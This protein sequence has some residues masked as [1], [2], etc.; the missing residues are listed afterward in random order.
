MT[1]CTNFQVV[2]HFASQSAPMK[3]LLIFV[4]RAFSWNHEY[5]YFVCSSLSSLEIFRSICGTL[6]CEGVLLDIGRN[7]WQC[8]VLQSQI[9]SKFPLTKKI[10]LLCET[11]IIEEFYTFTKQGTESALFVFSA[12]HSTFCC[13]AKIK[14][15]LLCQ[16]PTAFSTVKL[17][18]SVQSL[19][20]LLRN[21][22]LVFLWYGSFLRWLNCYWGVS[23]SSLQQT[24]CFFACSSRNP[25]IHCLVVV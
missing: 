15:R 20:L 24:R 19:C 23:S 25:V 22:F 18:L 9:S 5:I 13:S 1:F 11:N 6:C 12:A 17:A 10:C 8:L 21:N 14:L 16:T 3:L 4:L 2:A 7:L